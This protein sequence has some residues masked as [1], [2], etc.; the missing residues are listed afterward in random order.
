MDIFIWN[1]A[2][3][4]D[5]MR[6]VRVADES[7]NAETTLVLFKRIKQAWSKAR[8]I[9]LFFDNARYHHARMLKP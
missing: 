9:R 4:L 2:L 3:D 5:E 7:I 6:L 1:H 8:T